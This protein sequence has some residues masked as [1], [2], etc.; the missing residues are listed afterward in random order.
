M[1]V[2]MNKNTVF[3]AIVLFVTLQAGFIGLTY[4]M[5]KTGTGVKP[6]TG[7]KR[8]QVA[9]LPTAGSGADEQSKSRSSSD[10]GDKKKAHKANTG[11]KLVVVA[12]VPA[13]GNAPAKVVVVSPKAR[14]SSE[15]DAGLLAAP[16]PEKKAPEKSPR[17]GRNS[18]P[19][20][21]KDLP[22]EQQLEIYCNQVLPTTLQ[23]LFMS[24]PAHK[25]GTSL[26]DGG[27]FDKAIIK[28]Y[29]EQFSDEAKIFTI[30]QT[31][32]IHLL[33]HEIG[34]LKQSIPADSKAAGA[35]NASNA[36][37]E[38]RIKELE[39]AN[40]LLEE[41]IR[42]MVDVKEADGVRQANAQL[43]QENTQLKRDLAALRQAAQQ[44]Q[45]RQ[46]PENSRCA[47]L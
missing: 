1:E 10:S 44:P 17:G 41:R 13:M 46:Q 19:V 30:I 31:Y 6:G 16:A 5:K 38:Q 2:I 22:A 7:I 35:N 11:P 3:K 39:S 32:Y 21:P 37:Q 24:H 20:N 9:P 33:E 36:A 45:Q 25:M 14:S 26:K 12:A 34:L 40:K 18:V 23:N 47:I 8:S 28:R 29:V 42:G 15:T 27:P 43:Q 4:G